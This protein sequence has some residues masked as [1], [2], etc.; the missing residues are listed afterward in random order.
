DLCERVNVPRSAVPAVT[1]VDYSARLQTVDNIRN[2]RLHRLLSNFLQRTGCPILVNTSF[3]V[4]GEPIVCT[5]EDAFRCFMSTEMDVLVLE[6]FVIRRAAQPSLPA[7]D[8][9]KYLAAFGL[10]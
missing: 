6:N 7:V 10:D 2:P 4:R 8:R 1:H 9:E 3:N 5:P